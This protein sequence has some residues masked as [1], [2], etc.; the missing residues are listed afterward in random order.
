MYIKCKNTRMEVT[1]GKVMED[2]QEEFVLWEGKNCKIYPCTRTKEKP[3]QDSRRGEIAFTIKSYPPEMLRGL[4]QNLVYA[5]QETPET[6]PDLPLR[7]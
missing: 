4:K 5:Y 6:E 1:L 2:D 7:V 3:Q